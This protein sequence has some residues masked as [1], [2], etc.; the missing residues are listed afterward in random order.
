M[1]TKQI[2][3]LIDAAN[4]ELKYRKKVATAARHINK[5][6]TGLSVDF[7]DIPTEALDAGKSHHSVSAKGK[8]S[9]R[10]KSAP[11]KPKYISE[12]NLNQWSGRGKPPGWVKDICEAKN[13]SLADFKKSSLYLIRK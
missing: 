11:V 9:T 5:V 3:S 1:T 12:D 13:I 6:L 7:K 2:E 8:S 4:D 10:K